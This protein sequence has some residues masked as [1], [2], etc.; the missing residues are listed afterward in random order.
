MSG[1]INL[2]GPHTED[3]C[4]RASLASE[5]VSQFKRWEF[6]EITIIGIQPANAVLEQDSRDVCIGDKVP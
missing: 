2:P 3:Y 1:L 6:P 5:R 4:G